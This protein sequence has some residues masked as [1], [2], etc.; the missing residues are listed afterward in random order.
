MKGHF[1]PADRL[2]SLPAPPSE[3]GGDDG[4][5]LPLPPAIEALRRNGII[6]PHHIAAARF[7][8]ADY[9]IGVMGQ[10]DPQLDRTSCGLSHRPLNGR[11]GSINRYRYIH[12]IIGYRYER[13]L[14]AALIHGRPAREETSRVVPATP[15]HMDGVLAL[16]LDMLTRHYDAMPGHLWEG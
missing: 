11:R 8:A 5:G 10:E 12:G 9:R 14:I 1:L 2:F 13:I 15:Q 4:C 7:W 6:A 16:L 3:S